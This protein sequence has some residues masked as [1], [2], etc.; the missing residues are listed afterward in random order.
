M[1]P[2]RADVIAAQRMVR[3]DELAAQRDL[4]I[5]QRQTLKTLTEAREK[6]VVLV[7]EASPDVARSD[8]EPKRDPATLVEQP[9]DM[10]WQDLS[11]S[12][13]LKFQ[14]SLDSKDTDGKE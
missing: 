10:S 3:K 9:I 14:E 8:I 4:I 1:Y 2:Y 6:V 13:M 11:P 12:S 7:H 5:A